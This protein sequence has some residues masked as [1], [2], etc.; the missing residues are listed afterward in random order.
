[1]RACVRACVCVLDEESQLLGM[2]FTLSG[3]TQLIL[4]LTSLE[5][6]VHLPNNYHPEM[7][8]CDQSNKCRLET[9]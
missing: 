6:T 7:I 8:R 5:C 3:A 2:R 4:G 9:Q 1:M